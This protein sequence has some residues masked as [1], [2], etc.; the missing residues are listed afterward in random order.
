MRSHRQQLI[1]KIFASRRADGLWQVIPP[2]HKSYPDYLHYVPNYRASLWALLL[3]A[4]LKCDRNDERIKTPLETVK[5]HLFDASYGIYS[6]KEDHFPIPCLNGNMLYLQGY[7]CDD[8]DEKSKRVIDFFCKY[9]RFDDGQYEEPK[10]QFCTNTS[11]YGKH[12]CYWGVVKLLKGISFIPKVSRKEDLLKLRQ[13][14]LD[15]VLKHKVCYSSRRPARIMINKIDALTFPN[16]YKADFLEILWIL[17]R[18]GVSSEALLPALELLRSKRRGDGQ[19]ELERKMN[20]MLVSIGSINQPNFFIS[21]RAQEVVD[22]YA[23][24]VGAEPNVNI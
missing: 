15:F 9:Q 6:L 23:D 21:E 22:Y 1:E 12:T 14:C 7:F 8:L 10:N 4:D 2:T 24:L 16:F 11:C 13:K 18:E 17:K 3:L 5:H 19:W 20:N